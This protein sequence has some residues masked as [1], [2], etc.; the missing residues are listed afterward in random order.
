MAVGKVIPAMPYMLVPQQALVA[1][2]GQQ[3][4]A[5]GHTTMS[6]PRHITFSPARYPTAGTLLVS[7]ASRTI[8]HTSSTAN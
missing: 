1:R 4:S 8:D 3:V 5:G 6:I 7:E 2:A